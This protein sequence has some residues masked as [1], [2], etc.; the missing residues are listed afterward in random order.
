PSGRR[1]ARTRRATCDWSG[2]NGTRSTSTRWSS[3]RTASTWT[4]WTPRRWATTAWHC[5]RK[6]PSPLCGSA[7]AEETTM[8]QPADRPDQLSPAYK[9][10]APG[11]TLCRDVRGGT[12]TLRAK[13]E[14]YLPRFGVEPEEDWNARVAMTFVPSFLDQAIE[15]AVGLITR[16]DPQ[17]AE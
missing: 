10:M 11:W 9:A 6:P 3:P 7:G 2:G 8:T 12:D 15:L 5:N 13:K 4:T 16:H 1:T 17:L 14:T